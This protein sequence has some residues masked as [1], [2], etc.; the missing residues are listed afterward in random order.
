MRALRKNSLP[1]RLTMASFSASPKIHAP[2]APR[3]S[4]IA[5]NCEFS[6]PTRANTVAV[7]PLICSPPNSIFSGTAP[8]S[9]SNSGCNSA[10]SS[11]LKPQSQAV[12]EARSVAK[13]L[14]S[15][16]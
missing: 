13:V 16:L 12:I 15:A 3:I 4:V 5:S 10:N 1:S 8:A 2:P 7:S 9:F 11:A 6:P 14:T